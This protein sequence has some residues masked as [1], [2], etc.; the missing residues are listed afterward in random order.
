MAFERW[1]PKINDKTRLELLQKTLIYKANIDCWVY[2]VITC[3]QQICI[4]HIRF[5]L[6]VISALALVNK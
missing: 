2:E 5:I 1:F 3:D 6:I 4:G